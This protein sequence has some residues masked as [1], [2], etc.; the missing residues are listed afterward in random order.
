MMKLFLAGDQVRP[1]LSENGGKCQNSFPRFMMPSNPSPINSMALQGTRSGN[2]ILERWAEVLSAKGDVPALFA[3]DGTVER[4]FADLQTEAS[5]WAGRLAGF[6]VVALQMRNQPVW[7]AV[8]LGAWQAGGLVVLMDA[9]LSG[10]RRLRVEAQS[11]V[12]VRVEGSG[13]IVGLENPSAPRGRER[14]DLLKLSSGTNGEVRAIRFTAAQLMA[15]GDTVC[16]TMGLRETDRNYGA[17]S[18]AHSYGFS[19]LITP[20]L[21]RGISLVVADDMM[22]RALLEGLTKSRATVFPAV[23]ALF[24]A[25]AGIVPQTIN[26]RL[27][28]SAGAPLTAEVANAFRQTWGRKVHSFYGASECGGICYDGSDDPVPEGFVGSAMQGVTVESLGES[29]S[30]RI[31]VRS[32]AVGLGYQ[33]SEEEGDLSFGVFR[34]ADLLERTET[35]YVIKGRISA[36]INVAGRK[37][38]PQEIAEVV[39]LCPGVSEV[40]VVGLPAASRGEEVAVCVVGVVTDENLK[41][42]CASRLA[43]WKVPRHFRVLRQLPVNGRGKTSVETLRALFEPEG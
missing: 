37:V 34:P 38:S 2:P 39:S 18:F 3:A 24:R 5:Q 11:G 7:P 13:E 19:N 17:I 41:E 15:D 6:P 4:T 10:E 43:A 31:E 28:V 42:F 27:C 40:A 29:S 8:L 32:A 36:I 20:L 16:G 12:S 33:P 22:P 26:L 25:L 35:G 23:P 1:G 30:G 9:D 14:P 21:C